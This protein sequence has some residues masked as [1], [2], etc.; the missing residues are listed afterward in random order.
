MDELGPYIVSRVSK[1]TPCVGLAWNLEWRSEVSNT[2]SSPKGYKSNWGGREKNE[3]GSP[4]PRAYPGWF[5]RIWIRYE[6]DPEFFDSSR[7]LEAERIYPGTGGAGSYDGI[8]KEIERAQYLNQIPYKKRIHCYGW[9]VKIWDWDW[10]EISE[11]YEKERAWAALKNEEPAR[12]KHKFSWT[13]PDTLTEDRKFINNYLRTV[14][15]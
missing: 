3:D 6:P 2:H 7:L 12:P 10:P 5:G 11:V 8:W 13:D 14:Q 15:E 4:V 9:D 1:K